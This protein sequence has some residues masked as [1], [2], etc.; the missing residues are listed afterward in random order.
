MNNKW[1]KGLIV[2]TGVIIATVT[3]ALAVGLVRDK[4]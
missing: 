4:Q 1:T 2:A 3:I